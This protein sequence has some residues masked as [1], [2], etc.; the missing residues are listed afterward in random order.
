MTLHPGVSAEFEVEVGPADT[1]VALGSGELEVLG[2]PRVVALVEQ[3]TV[4]AVAEHLDDGQTTVGI[5]VALRHRR[6]SLL[7]DRVRVTAELV[8]IVGIR[9]T[10]DV[11]VRGGEALLADGRVQRAVVDGVQFMARLQR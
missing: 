10:F 4:R 7:G 11:S 8:E 5:E 2:T 1:A 3:A 6:A 9:L